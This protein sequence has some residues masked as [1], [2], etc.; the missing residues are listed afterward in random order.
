MFVQKNLK[1]ETLIEWM[2][3]V[4]ISLLIISSL[5]EIY[6]ASQRGYHVQDAL[7]HLQDNAKTASDFLKA[8]IQ[9][10]GY[11]GCPLLTND[12]PIATYSN[13]YSITPQNKLIGTDTQL[14]VR[15]LTFPNVVLKNMQDAS[16]LYVSKEVTLHAGDIL[17]ISDC[18]HAEIFQAQTVSSSQSSQ[19]IITTTPLQNKY[20]LY[21]EVGEF[22]IN[23]YYIDKSDH[24]EKDGSP[25]YSLFVK[26]I[27]GKT[28]LVAGIHHMQLAYS[29]YQE[30]K[31]ID[32]P[33]NKVTDWSSIVG[34]AID[35][36]LH[37]SQIN[38]TWH[39]YVAI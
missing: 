27:D 22:T 25:I 38:K 12:F 11:I 29:L 33:A 34:V 35:L 26:T 31:L 5:V 28:E 32:V 2:I 17:M 18:Y 16:T 8:D 15:R 30:G 4:A 37:S 23:T 9:H 13:E 36:D 3:T 39:V 14:T 24:H 21:A 7:N 19:K 20:E 10:A 6:L 1:G